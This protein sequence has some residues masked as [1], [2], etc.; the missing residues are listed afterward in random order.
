MLKAFAKNAILGSLLK[1]CANSKW[2]VEFCLCVQGKCGSIQCHC[3]LNPVRS[4]GFM[5]WHCPV[6]PETLM[7]MGTYHIG[8]SR[9]TCLFVL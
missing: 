5:C 2:I 6:S 7:M 3:F 9:R 1:I 8:L 4:G